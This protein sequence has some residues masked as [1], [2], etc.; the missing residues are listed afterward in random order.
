M[1]LGIFHLL[2][3][4]IWEINLIDRHSLKFPHSLH[5]SV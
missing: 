3:L 5:L 2:V 4:V 1:N